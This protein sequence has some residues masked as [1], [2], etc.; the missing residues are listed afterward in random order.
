[1]FTV[2]FSK[3]QRLSGHIREYEFVTQ[4]G[5]ATQVLPG[6]PRELWQPE[7]SAAASKARS[8]VGVS[9]Q[10]TQGRNHTSKYCSSKYL[11]ISSDAKMDDIHEARAAFQDQHHSFKITNT[12]EV[13]HY[14]IHN[15]QHPRNRSPNH[16]RGTY[17]RRRYSAGF[18][19]F[20][21]SRLYPHRCVQQSS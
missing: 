14:G 3:S 15:L 2:A 20:R 11:V 13:H 4:T 6:T 8:S 9:S 5:Q 1:M 7:G 12:I 10:F 17:A 18:L 21:R 19:T 16:V